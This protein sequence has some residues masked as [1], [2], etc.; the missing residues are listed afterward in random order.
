M[1]SHTIRGILC[2]LLVCMLSLMP[3]GAGFAT[4]GMIIEPVEGGTRTKDDGMNVER[5]DDGTVDPVATEA[6]LADAPSATEEPAIVNTMPQTIEEAVGQFL[7]ETLAGLTETLEDPWQRYVCQ[8]GYDGLEMNLSKFDVSKGKPLSVSFLIADGDPLFKSLA[9]N[10]DPAATLSAALV[11]MGLRDTKVKLNLTI[12][13]ADGGYTATYAKN[14][15]KSLLKSIKSA[16]AKGV[17]ACD[18]KTMLALLVDYYLP[19][20]VETQKKAPEAFAKCAANPAYSAYIT[21]NQLMGMDYLPALYYANRDFKLDAEGGPQELRLTW[22]A[23]NLTTLLASAGKAAAINVAYIN[24]IKNYTREQQRACLI[25]A[26]DTEAIAFHHAKKTDGFDVGMTVD[27]LTLPAADPYIVGS[28]DAPGDVAWAV[29]ELDSVI[30]GLPDYPAVEKPKNGVIYGSNKGTKCIFKMP[31]DGNSYA[32]SIYEAGSGT[33]IAAV[34]SND[35]KS[36]TVRVPKGNVYFIVAEGT[37]WYG[38]EHL[39]GETGGYMRTEEIEIASSR[40]YHT[41]TIHPKDGGNTNVYGLD[42]SDLFD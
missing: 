28:T 12:A 1:R 19:S 9:E 41:F 31:K 27:L 8:Q 3:A 14:A 13:L 37:V 40:Y 10:N 15:E 36:V 18:S 29:D 30:W 21:R 34:F 5:V 25:S 38:K 4:G 33:Q 23:P 2:L 42:Y 7:T 26:L 6:P 24:N 32:I 39:F 35:G 16:A 22:K 17:K 20:P 11:N